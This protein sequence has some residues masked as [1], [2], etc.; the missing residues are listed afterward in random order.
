[1]NQIALKGLLT[2]KV[3][4]YEDAPILVSRSVKGYTRLG[5]HCMARGLL[6]S[7]KVKTTEILEV[8]LFSLISY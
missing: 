5:T 8:S 1:M 4:I 7:G 2:C 6:L 3:G